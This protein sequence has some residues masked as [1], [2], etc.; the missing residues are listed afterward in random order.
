MIRVLIADDNKDFARQLQAYL[1]GQEDM[2]VV[3][4]ANEGREVL[5][6]LQERQPDVLLLDLIMPVMDGISVLE[7]L[8]R[9]KRNLPPE[10]ASRF[11]KIL[12]ISAFGHE[13]AVRRASELGA[14]YILLKPFSLEALAARIREL[15][16][17]PGGEGSAQTSV[18]P[19]WGRKEGESAEEE[20]APE[21]DNA[22]LDAQITAVLHEIGVPAHIKGYKYL[23]EA[24][25]MVYKNM[26]ILGSITKVL[27][28]EIARK[29]NTMPTRV[30][31]AI[32]HAIEVAWER[33]S[34][35]AVLK[36]F[37]YTISQSRAKPTN[38]EF[39]AMIADKLRVEHS[40]RERRMRKKNASY[41]S[42]RLE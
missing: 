39:I 21:L 9:E 1:E 27:Y 15:V 7:H 37:G 34:P 5:R 40:I 24:I 28:P 41:S 33:G 30:E 32:R 6:L 42:D 17:S 10:K 20:A 3:G 2:E 13:D 19:F 22:Y 25:A 23:R 12:V 8:S 16:G 26:E 14:Q 35:D 36:Y 4:V 29:Y 38:S 18:V 31:R 11:P